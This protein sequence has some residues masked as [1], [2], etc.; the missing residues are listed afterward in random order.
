MTRDTFAVSEPHFLF[1]A[2]SSRPGGHSAP[3]SSDPGR[4]PAE[5]RLE[6]RF[7]SR[8]PRPIELRKFRKPRELLGTLP[9]EIRGKDNTRLRH[10]RRTPPEVLLSPSGA[11]RGPRAHAA[12]NSWQAQLFAI[13]QFGGAALRFPRRVF[14]GGNFQNSEQRLEYSGLFQVRSVAPGQLCSFPR[15]WR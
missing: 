2:P 14:S 4:S 7:E 8:L 15:S 11:T 6:F 9:N 10:V 3:L 5:N 1:E 13:F 12:R